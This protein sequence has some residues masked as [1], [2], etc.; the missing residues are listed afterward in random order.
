MPH[1]NNILGAMVCDP[2]M[3]G[4][5]V[6]YSRETVEF[7]LALDGC[8]G[9]KGHAGAVSSFASAFCDGNGNGR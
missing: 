7:A 5:R 9:G 4:P 1:A 6:L 3:R 8:F 2:E